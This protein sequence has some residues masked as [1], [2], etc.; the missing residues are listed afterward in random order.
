MNDFLILNA[1]KQY[2]IAS[3]LGKKAMRHCMLLTIPL[4]TAC[5]SP[6]DRAPSFSDE[7][8]QAPPNVWQ[9]PFS[10]NDKAPNASSVKSF[11][12]PTVPAA[13]LEK[14]KTQFNDA[15]PLNLAQLIDLAQRENPATRQAWNRAREAALSVGLTE[16]LFLPIISANVVTG[17]QRIRVPAPLSILGYQPTIQNHITETIP[18]LTLTWLLFDFGGRS[19]IKEGA[20]YIALGANILFNA[21]HQKIIRDVTD[22]YYQYDAARMRTQLA[23]EALANHEKVE[24]AA[25]ARLKGGL[26]TRV[27]LALAHQAVAQGKL[28]LVTSQGM[29]RNAYQALLASVGLSPTSQLNVVRPTY[30]NLPTEMAQ[31]TERHMQEAL[32]QRP[33]IAAAYAAVRAAEAGERATLA[34]YMPKV[35]L[36]AALAKN[37]ANFEVGSLPSLNQQAT[38]SG[39]LLGVTIPLY[40]GGLRSTQRQKAKIHREEAEETL[41]SLQNTAIREMIA[42]ESLLH[43]ALQSH[44]AALDLIETTRI[45]HDAALESYKEGLVTITLATETATQLNKAQQ[46]LADARYAALASS[47]NLAFLTGTMVSPQENWLPSAGNAAPRVNP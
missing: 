16:A 45:A 32:A 8:W 33:D 43:T 46:A 41:R 13:A 7:P 39:V 44:E 5:V 26:A 17:Y 9:E 28:Y 47:A 27:D 35:F 14:P 22:H 21:T 42:A 15:T 4:L 31:L 38:T 18:A 23:I 19:A 40:D 34:A 10:S 1:L 24:E 20:Q 11:T 2:A 30:T 37:N 29:E 36:G 6:L 3:T 25:K 12:I